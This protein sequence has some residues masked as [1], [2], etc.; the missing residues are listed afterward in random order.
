MTIDKTVK[1]FFVLLFCFASCEVLFAQRDPAARFV[2]KVRPES[3]RP[4]YSSLG[5]SFD[6]PLN[7]YWRRFV[8]GGDYGQYKEKFMGGIM[9][10]DAPETSGGCDWSERKTCWFNDPEVR[11]E[12]RRRLLRIPFNRDDRYLWSTDGSRLHVFQQRIIPTNP[13]LIT[14]T[15]E[16][17]RWETPEFARRWLHST[18]DFG[19]GYAAAD[20]RKTE[21]CSPNDYVG[22]AG[23]FDNTLEQTFAAPEPTAA[24]FLKL[25]VTDRSIYRLRLCDRRTG[26]EIERRIFRG[27]EAHADLWTEWRL[28]RELPPGDYLVELKNVAHEVLGTTSTWQTNAKYHYP[29]G[30]YG[31]EWDVYPDGASGMNGR[32]G[33]TPYGRLRASW[34]Y[35]TADH[36]DSTVVRDGLTIIVR[37]DQTG[38]PVSM[39]NRDSVS[40]PST[41]YDLVRSGY[42]DAFTNLRWREAY[43][44]MAMIERYFG[45]PEKAEECRARVRAA[46]CAFRRTFWN[47]ETGRYVG[48]IDKNGDVWDYGEVAINLMAVCSNHQASEF[49]G[50]DDL[51]GMKAEHRQILDWIHGRREVAGDRSRGADIYAFGFAPRKNTV[52]YETLGL[53]KNHWWGGWYYTMRPE[54]DG[55]GNFGLQEENGGTNP[56]LSYY[57]VMA[58]LAV[59]RESG[60]PEERERFIAEAWDRF[61]AAEN[62]LLKEFVKDRFY[63]PTPHPDWEPN[64]DDLY[65]IY[66][67]TLPESGMPV[68]AVLDGFMGVRVTPDEIRVDPRLPSGVEFLGVRDLLFQGTSYEIEARR[69][70]TSRVEPMGSF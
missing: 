50:I 44:A 51:E 11:G 63:R 59:A 43:Y 5:E 64:P 55:R 7:D 67:M 21:L 31:S 27:K 68:N 24:V 17:L 25:M 6:E 10:W 34:D 18:Q 70:G 32:V 61:Y 47:P 66:V 16:V 58:T 62:S 45:D 13:E 48:W 28:K 60:T 8:C 36:D 3:V 2:H 42:K 65:Q 49:G 9:F 29:I 54:G 38:V 46:V 52:P 20:G 15:W 1:I 35:M 23:D 26:E 56:C 57:D 53:E 33:E 12:L 22:R 30:W 19:I 39:E 40:L 37:P 41:S 69:G 14:K 4:F